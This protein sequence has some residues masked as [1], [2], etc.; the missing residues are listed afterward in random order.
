MERNYW[1]MKTVSLKELK[2]SQDKKKTLTTEWFSLR[3]ILSYANWAF[4]YILLGGREAGKSYSVTEFF[5]RQYR[6][7][8]IP[9]VWL[10]LT[11]KQANKLLNN[12]A[13][14]LVDPDLRRKYKL[15]LVTSG[16]NV[17][18][19]TKRSKKDKEGKTKVIEKEL[20]ARVYPLSTYYNDKGSLFDKDFLDD[21]NMRYN[22][23][24]DEFERES[25]EK[26]T[27]DIATA[28]INQLETLVRSTKK[29]IK[30][31]FLGNLLEDASDIL[32]M[33][34]F[35]PEEFGVYKLKSRKCVIEYIEPSEAYLK[36][37]K[38]TIADLLMGNT[39]NSSFTNKQDT[40][41][42][43]VDKSPLVAP[44]YV[45]KFFKDKNKW[46][47]VWNDNIIAKYNGEQK[48]A[49]AMRPYLDEVYQVENQRQIVYEFDTRCFKFRNLIT[50]KQ[51]QSEI[52]RL[53]PR[54]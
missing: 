21:P 27:F 38:G 19:V 46:F 50:F 37:R 44:K 45:I 43:L 39:N 36:R 53:K 14:K 15:D 32:C 26:N 12:N 54:K 25:G 52:E 49:I 30:I 51:F 40:D 42:T 5:C 13:E 23:A 17:Y 7:K 4:F 10:R 35:I 28:L 33:F 9:F 41:N 24:I 34:N 47:T 31:F 48:R 2:A 6:Y 11:D 22:I 16:N 18:N 1:L 20:F 3:H 8:H 29:N